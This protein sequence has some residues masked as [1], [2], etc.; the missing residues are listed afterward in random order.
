MTRI[1]ARFDIS[2]PIDD[3]PSCWAYMPR[4]HRQ[5]RLLSGDISLP[6]LHLSCFFWKPGL[7]GFLGLTGHEGVAERQRGLFRRHL[8]CDA[9]GI[10]R[11]E[12]GDR[13][14]PVRNSITTVCNEERAR[15][16]KKKLSSRPKFGNRPVPE[17]SYEKS[18]FLGVAPHP[19][20]L[21]LLAEG[22]PRGDHLVEVQLHL[23]YGTYSLRD[24]AQRDLT[25][26]V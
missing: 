26:F 10:P 9:E 1:Y 13:K 15:E 2:K 24:S 19:H 20:I 21:R 8:E 7:G 5:W 14:R 25:L 3:K 18:S 4:K 16:K 11:G 23:K 22:Q 12:R 17:G 6:G